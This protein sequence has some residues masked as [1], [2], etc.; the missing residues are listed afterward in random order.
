MII[1]FI[2]IGG[3]AVAALAVIYKQKGCQV[4]GSDL[5][6]SE[7]TQSVK[8]KGIQVFISHNPELITKKI[9]LVIFSEAVA[10]DNI[11]LKKARELNIKCQP[12]AQA[13]ADLSQL[14][15]TIAVSGMHGKTTTCCLLAQAMLKAGLDPSFII[16][17]KNGGRLGKSRYLVIEADDYQ[18]KF[19][20]YQPN[21]LILTNIEEEH[22]DYFR[23]LEHIKKVFK[24]YATQVKDLIIA[25][26]DDENIKEVVRA[27]NCPV[28]YYTAN[29]LLLKI[30]GKHNQYNAA[31]ALEA[32]KALGIEQKRAEHY[33]EQCQG[34]WRRFQQGLGKIQDKEFVLIED[35]GHH[36]TEI[37]ATMKAVRQKFPQTT[38]ILVFQPHQ[39]QRT[40]YLRNNFIRTFRYLLKN[41]FCNKLILTDI[42]EVAGR[43]DKKIEQKISSQQIAEKV[44]EKECVFMSRSEIVNFLGKIIK[45]REVVVMMGAGDIYEL[46]TGIRV[47]P[48]R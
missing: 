35:Y 10:P 15:F 29:N 36:P 28:K 19:L 24:K 33:L 41:R 42:Y 47:D 2:G 7:I 45:S 1:H 20:N 44:G 27:A 46:S 5:A 30:P 26:K 9:N 25:N 3:V 31:A 16:G 23:N 22:M 18:A 37:K 40:F 38:I 39:Y 14:Y 11:E 6:Q 21:I 48:L 34:A 13:I 4:Q 43:E 12:A 17:T 8:E 32:L